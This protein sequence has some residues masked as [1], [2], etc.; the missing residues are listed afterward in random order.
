MLIQLILFSSLVSKDAGFA[1]AALAGLAS[2]ENF[3]KIELRK[4]DPSVPLPGGHRYLPYKPLMLLHVKG[5]QI[6]LSFL[7]F[8]LQKDTEKFLVKLNNPICF[9]I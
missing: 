1:E 3:S 8:F 9:I 5:K 6:L 2:K 7:Y 4:T